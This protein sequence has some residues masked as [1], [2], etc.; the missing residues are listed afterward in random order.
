MWFRSVPVSKWSVYP[1]HVD[2][3]WGQR[4]WRQRWWTELWRRWWHHRSTSTTRYAVC[5]QS[6]FTRCHVSS[7]LALVAATGGIFWITEKC[8]RTGNTILDIKC[9]TFHYSLNAIVYIFH[10]ALRTYLNMAY[11]FDQ[12]KEFSFAGPYGCPGTIANILMWLTS[13]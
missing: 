6:L 4:L 9:Y 1:R 5:L 11:M 3:W 12:F 10:L 2:M 7:L 8:A 13:P